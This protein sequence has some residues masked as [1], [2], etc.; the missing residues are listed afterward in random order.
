MLHTELAQPYVGLMALAAT[1][2][3][4]ISDIQG[5]LWPKREVFSFLPQLGHFEQ[6]PPL[7]KI[8][9]ILLIK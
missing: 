3:A 7:H 5:R 2:N 9:L 1:P 6:T 8:Q 4:C